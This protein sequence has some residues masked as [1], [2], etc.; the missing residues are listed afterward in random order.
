MLHPLCGSIFS[1]EKEYYRLLS[2]LLCYSRALWPQAGSLY[3]CTS[4]WV[5]A[6]TRV[7]LFLLWLTSGFLHYIK[8]PSAL[9]RLINGWEITPRLSIKTPL[10][11]LPTHLLPPS[12]RGGA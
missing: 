1:H 4:D 12:D 10:P 2:F 3:P 11:S 9:L 8:R 7:L 6:R 5:T